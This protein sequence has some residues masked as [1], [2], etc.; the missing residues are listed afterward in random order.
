MAKKRVVAALALLLSM[1]LILP[2]FVGCDNAPEE[3]NCPK[4][5]TYDDNFIRGP[6]YSYYPPRT[7]TL[8]LRNGVDFEC[9]VIGEP[10]AFENKQK[11]QTVKSGEGLLIAALL[12]YDVA[13][14]GYV[15]II[16]K[17]SDHIVGYAVLLIKVDFPEDST[18]EHGWYVSTL[19]AVEFPRNFFSYQEITEEYV[20]E[21]FNELMK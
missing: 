16:A 20:Q 2:C 1:V 11:T 13:T 12:R 14:D 9:C 6:F 17:Q 15:T 7:L 19:K 21:Q 10:F 5:I 3:R 8:A 4:M 18:I